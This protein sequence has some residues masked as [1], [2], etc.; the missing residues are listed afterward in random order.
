ME[1]N[2]CPRGVIIIKISVSDMKIYENLL[3]KLFYRW[4]YLE[5]IY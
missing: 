1:I 5:R 4:F 3:K 2:S